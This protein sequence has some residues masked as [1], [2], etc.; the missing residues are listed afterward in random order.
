V[1]WGPIVAESAST[2]CTSASLRP[3]TAAAMLCRLISKS[4]A[5]AETGAWMALV[6]R[7]MPDAEDDTPVTDDKCRRLS[8]SSELESLC[9]FVALASRA[10]ACR[11]QQKNR[12]PRT[13][14]TAA[15]S[16]FACLCTPA[17]DGR[18]AVAGGLDEGAGGWRG[19][20]ATR[21]WL[22][23]RLCAELLLA[24]LDPPRPSYV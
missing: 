22:C 6:S 23:T 4:S 15:A 14:T 8:S 1:A 7:M 3:S 18:L 16:K 24:P 21:A 10:R 20:V 9:A 5:E 19:L 12:K 11:V 13:R 17:S 2:L